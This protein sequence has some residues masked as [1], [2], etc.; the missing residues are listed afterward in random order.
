[1]TAPEPTPAEALAARL[2][3]RCDLTPDEVWEFLCLTAPLATRK[4]ADRWKRIAGRVA[5]AA[6]L[7]FVGAL[8]LLAAGAYLYAFSAAGVTP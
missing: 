5:V 6:A 4:A 3:E 7:V 1:M 8:M 2:H